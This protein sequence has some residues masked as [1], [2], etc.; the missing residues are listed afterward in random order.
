MNEATELKTRGNA[1]FQAARY[2]EATDCY[3]RAFMP[4]GDSKWNAAIL[5]N[6]AFAYLQLGTP[7]NLALAEEDCTTVLAT[8]PRNVKALYRR[9]LARSAMEKLSEAK[10]D[11]EA[12]VMWE[13]GNPQANEALDKIRV[14]LAAKTKNGL[15]NEDFQRQ[16]LQGNVEPSAVM[17]V[18]LR[19]KSP[20]QHKSHHH[21]H[22]LHNDEFAEALRQCSIAAHHE[23][24]THATRDQRAANAAWEELQAQ[25]Q[26]LSKPAPLKPKKRQTSTQK[27]K[28]IASQPGQIKAHTDALWA[29]MLEEESK[30][31]SVFQNKLRGR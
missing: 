19:L 20:R 5:S 22:H 29:Q 31:R 10:A 13:P 16:M 23:A 21:H 11:L 30:T 27:S 2:E 18:P 28:A 25:E 4:N 7:S 17:P 15:F 3:T 1:H 9:A 8:D 12:I 14:Q 26:R 24:Q 6:R